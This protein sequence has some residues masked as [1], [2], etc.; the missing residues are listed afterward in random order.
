[1]TVTDQ[2]KTLDKKYKQNEAQ[3]NLG[4][5]ATKIYALS[6]KDLDKYEY[7]IGEDLSYKPSTVE[8]AKFTYSPLSKIFSKKRLKEEDKKERPLKRL[9][10]IED[11]SE[12]QLK[13]IKSKNETI[14]EVTDFA[15]EP[16]SLEA[17]RLIEEIK[18]IQKRC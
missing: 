13:S 3:Y 6:S 8:Q 7:L 1:M 16:L 4:R 17:K 5:K 12:E 14:T 10:N 11:K 2:V 15:K 9:K 18:I